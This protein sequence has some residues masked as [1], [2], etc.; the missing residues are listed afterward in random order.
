LFFLQDAVN[1]NPPFVDS[2]GYPAVFR[3]TFGADVDPGA[4]DV[5]GG[6]GHTALECARIYAQVIEGLAVAPPLGRAVQ[7]DLA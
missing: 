2:L 4:L 1:L 7:S 3:F 5:P 6:Y